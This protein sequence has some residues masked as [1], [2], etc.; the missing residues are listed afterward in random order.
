MPRQPGQYPG[1]FDEDGNNLRSPGENAAA[2]LFC[3]LF[4]VKEK[5]K[6]HAIEAFN[7]DNK[8]ED[9]EVLLVN[10][11]Y[12]KDPLSWDIYKSTVLSVRDLLEKE[13]NRR[14]LVK[15]ENQKEINSDLIGI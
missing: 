13:I 2:R 1:F 3:D 14:S 11:E 6:Y 12:E 10:C 15:K 5:A 4:D 9:V 8:L 7:K